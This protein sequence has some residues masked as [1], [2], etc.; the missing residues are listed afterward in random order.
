MSRSFA[1]Q[2]AALAA[3]VLLGGCGDDD[4][5]PPRPGNCPVTAPS[6]GEGGAGAGPGEEVSLSCVKM[7]GGEG[8]QWV[9]GLAV[10]SQGNFYVTGVFKGTLE[11]GGASLDAGAM[12][13]DEYVAKFDAA[14]EPLWAFQLEQSI[15]SLDGTTHLKVGVGPDDMPVIAGDLCSETAVVTVGGDSIA[16]NGQESDLF[17]VKLDADGMLAWSEP[18]LFARTVTDV[19]LLGIAFDGAGNVHLVGD[20]HAGAPAQLFMATALDEAIFAAKIAA[21][22]GA[23]IWETQFSQVGSLDIVGAGV[24]VDDDGNA[25]VIGAFNGTLT[26][27]DEELTTVGGESESD[28]VV[29]KL[30][31]AG[32]VLWA[33]HFVG[34]NAFQRAHAVTVDHDGNAYVGGTYTGELEV[35]L[36]EP[37]VSFGPDDYDAFVVKLTPDG[38][39]EWA[40]AP[41]EAEDQYVYALALDTLERV[42]VGGRFQ[43]DF[44]LGL[45]LDAQQND[46]FVVVLEADATVAW[47][48]Q[49]GSTQQ[50]QIDVV[51]GVP[52]PPGAVVFGGRAGSDILYGMENL[53]NQGGLDILLGTYVLPEEQE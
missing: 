11:I 12:A 22:D 36:D 31:D 18:V 29:I 4:H 23:L 30:S 38:Q 43:G 32:D 10:D 2:G 52:N 27:G 16:R 14:C 40:V 17:A 49:I 6:C 25:I 46:G 28:V 19:Q 3:W 33:R 44:N 24:A 13:F 7:F 48:R 35:G 1:W 8:D 21:A 5:L 50:D 26:V 15:S 20:L 9:E 37:L 39:S 45:P 47:S 42:V 34:D 53:L 51:V 41:A